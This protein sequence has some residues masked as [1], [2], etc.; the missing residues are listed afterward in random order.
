MVIDLSERTDAW[1][2]VIER[3]NDVLAAKCHLTMRWDVSGTGGN[4]TALVSTGHGFEVL[5]T[6]DE[7]PSLPAAPDPHETYTVGIYDGATSH[8]IDQIEHQVLI[9][10]PLA[11]QTL[12]EN[13][14]RRN[15]A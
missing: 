12:I 11:V 15:P 6:R 9:T 4:C 2:P 13:A 3:T 14:T 5:V 8:L 10:I 1:M 7:E